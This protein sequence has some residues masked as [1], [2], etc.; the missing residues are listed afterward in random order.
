ML[1]LFD[2][3]RPGCLLCIHSDDFMAVAVQFIAVLDPDEQAE[4]DFLVEQA[5][6]RRAPGWSR[7]RPMTTRT[8]ACRHGAENGHLGAALRDPTRWIAVSGHRTSHTTAAAISSHD[9]P[10]HR[11]AVRTGQRGF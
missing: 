8:A 9:V 11:A 5:R 3:N 7:G 1:A 6:T 4:L 10:G 2:K